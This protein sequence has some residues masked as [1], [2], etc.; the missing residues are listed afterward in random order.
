[1]S[2]PCSLTVIPDISN[3]GSSVFGLFSAFD[4]ERH[5]IPAF[6]GM[7]V[8][9]GRRWGY[10]HTNRPC[11]RAACTPRDENDASLQSVILDI[12]NRGS[13]VFAVGISPSPLVGEGRGEGES[14]LQPWIL[15]CARNDRRRRQGM[16]ARAADWMPVRL[17]S[18]PVT[19][20]TVERR[21][22][23]PGGGLRAPRW[24]RR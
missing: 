17:C 13:S 18:S 15:A 21:E 2:L 1:M 16:T 14:E 12:L 19:E 10:F 23:R 3:R 24:G 6:A 8:R 11:R 5:W 7:T 22:L 4:G 20:S 9:G